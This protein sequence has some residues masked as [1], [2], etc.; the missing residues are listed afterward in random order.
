VDDGKGEWWNYWTLDEL[1]AMVDGINR[2]IR[3]FGWRDAA[4]FKAVAAY[5][6]WAEAVAAYVYIAQRGFS[7]LGWTIISSY[8]SW[9]TYVW[10]VLV[11]ESSDVDQSVVL[12]D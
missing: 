3:R 9:P 11:V 10:D 4:G 1:K 2:T 12:T 8:M 5:D 7:L 6:D